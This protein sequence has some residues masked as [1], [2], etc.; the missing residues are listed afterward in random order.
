MH[1]T[2]NRTMV[3]RGEDRYH[4]MKDV[5][6][7]ERLDSKIEGLSSQEAQKRLKIT[8]RNEIE[9]GKKTPLWLKFLNQFRDPLVIVL[10]VAAVITF[11]I[12]PT[13]I[14]WIVIGAIV[15]INAGIGFAQ[16]EK[17]EAAIE[18]L[19]KLSAP[20]AVVFRDGNKKEIE[21]ANLVPGDVVYVESGMRVPADSR[22]LKSKNLKVREAALTGESAASEKEPEPLRENVPLAGRANTL[23]MSTTVETGHGTAVIYATGMRTEIGKIAGMLDE[24]KRIE[25]PLQKRLKHLGKILGALVLGV[26]FIIFVLEIL[27]ELSSLSWG[28]IKELFETAVSLAVAAIPEGLPAVVTISLAVG[29]KVMAGKNVIVRKL[30]VV[31]TLGSATTICTDKT[32]TLTT[33]TMNADVLHMRGAEIKI[34]GVGYEPKGGFSSDGKEVKT[35][36][37]D[38]T[39]EQIMMASAL[40]GDATISKEEDQ[41]QIVGDTTE[42]AVIVM[43]EKAGYGHIELRKKHPRIDER[44]FDSGRKM[45]STVHKID[46]KI[47]VYSKGAPERILNVCTS[48]FWDGVQHP[49]SKK[50]KKDIRRLMDSMA[51]EGYRTLAF[52]KGEE[53]QLER[54]MSFLG[55]VGIRDKIRPEAKKAIAKARGAGIRSLMITGDHLLTAS[56]IGKELQLI[57]E[58]KEAINCPD[59]DEMDEDEFQSI[60]RRVSVYSRASPEHKVRIVKGLKKQG[61]IVAMTGDGVNDAPALKNADIGVAMGITGTDVSKEA[62]D[63]ILTD[64]NYASIV[65]AVEEGRG[66][67]DNI[68]KVIQFLL[69]CNMGE[70]LV[71]F[72]AILIGWELPLVAL[73]ILWMNLVTDSFPALALVSEPKEPGLMKRRPRDPKEGAIT[74]DMVISIGISA[75]IITAG[76]LLVFWYNRDH[77]GRSLDLSRTVALTSMVMFQMWTAVA[78]RSTSHRMS[79]IGWFSNPK[80]LLAILGAVLLMLPIIYI[81]FLQDAFGTASLGYMEWMEILVVSVFGFIA[82]ELWEILNRRLFHLGANFPDMVK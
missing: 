13:G 11:I 81:P 27:R 59:L 52:A 37:L 31:E 43:A 63:M 33:G 65:S 38:S 46:G 47:M 67:Y 21:A 36:H 22:L 82:V 34:E 6:V 57:T 29:L 44:P 12:E 20:R 75:G 3:S 15:L 1:Q 45:M 74:K 51:G 79:E 24:V 76:T 71:M 7:L 49:L 2:F 61:N 53:D 18:S 10:L 62:S 26:C 30:P 80:L 23:F 42:G 28:T 35:S 19:K 5:E 48:E 66:I 58:D 50:R 72:T 70:V 77:L 14:D 9:K 16:E 40:C 4:L 54:D 55:V 60:L 73:Q 68:R 25:T 78:T 56:A 39:F 69:S 8:G 17:A 41:Y 64:D 32:G